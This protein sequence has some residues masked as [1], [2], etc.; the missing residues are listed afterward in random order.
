MDEIADQPELVHISVTT[1]TTDR[2]A[3]LLPSVDPHSSQ[4]MTDNTWEIIDVS[5]GP[6]AEDDEEE[7]ERE[8]EMFKAEGGGQGEQGERV[9]R[10]QHHWT[11]ATQTPE[12]YY[13]DLFMVDPSRVSVT[14]KSCFQ[15]D[16]SIGGWNV[17]DFTGQNSTQQVEW[18]KICGCGDETCV[19]N[20]VPK[21]IGEE[22]IKDLNEEV[23][24]Q[25]Q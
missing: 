16:K 21:T 25:Q 2:T 17:L 4:Y 15:P 8:E 24:Q 22:I 12:E 6:T 7:K 23:Q 11:S 5:I 13:A 9:F 19:L 10:D 3:D 14:R 18:I 20:C 1:S